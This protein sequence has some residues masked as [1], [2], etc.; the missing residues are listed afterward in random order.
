M[1]SI[2]YLVGSWKVL[3]LFVLHLI[4]LFVQNFDFVSDEEVL[5]EEVN[6]SCEWQWEEKNGFGSFGE[7][8][9]TPNG[10]LIRAFKLWLKITYFHREVDLSNAIGSDRLEGS[11]SG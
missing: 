1:Q 6:D 5:Q 2:E 10:A 4:V 3:D 9:T 11:P 8:V 7:A